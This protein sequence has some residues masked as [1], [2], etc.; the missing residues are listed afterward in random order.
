MHFNDFSSLRF[1]WISHELVWDC[2]MAK[3][4]LFS[5]PRLDILTGSQPSSLVLFLLWFSYPSSY[6]RSSIPSCCCSWRSR[7]GT[8]KWTFVGRAYMVYTICP[9]FPSTSGDASSIFVVLVPL[10]AGSKG[11]VQ[12]APTLCMNSETMQGY[13]QW[14]LKS[15]SCLKNLEMRDCNW[16]SMSMGVLAS[17]EVWLSLFPCGD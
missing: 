1:Y 2:V 3:I 4:V 5:G 7:L 16:M 11:H 6:A 8:S 14:Q 10:R 12:Y 9:F 15:G 13:K 17:L